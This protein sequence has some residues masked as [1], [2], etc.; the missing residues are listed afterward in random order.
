[1]SG[2]RDVLLLALLPGVGVAAGG[3]VAEITPR[4]RTWLNWSLH[5]AAGIVVAIAAIEVFPEASGTLS[6]WTIG[7]A[8]GVGGLA[9][10]AAQTLVDRYTARGD[11]RMWMIFLAVATDL[12]GDGLLI[13]AGT[14]VSASLGVVLA[15][16]QIMANVPEG[17]ASIATFRANDVQRPA[18]LW[19]I[20]AF[21]VPALVAALVGF[22]ILRDRPESWQY[23][24][25]VAAAGLYTVAAFE[26]VITEAH[27]AAADT[28]RSTLALIGG[29]VLFA[30]VSAALSS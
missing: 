6:G 4:S 8:F 22:L 1:M 17:F 7:I 26:D 24:A 5:G 14:A 27:E 30:F 19:L 12:F 13:G 16:G 15:I 28:R 18:R 21:V 9:Y 11:S 29:F 25:L 23:T 3:L 2:L 10:L 20:A